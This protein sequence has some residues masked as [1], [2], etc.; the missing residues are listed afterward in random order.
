MS[1][2][3]QP[4]NTFTLC[5]EDGNEYEINEFL[6]AAE[7]KNNNMVTKPTVL[8]SRYYKTA[9]GKDVNYENEEY[10][11]EESSIKLYSCKSS[12]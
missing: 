10:I 12:D 8:P 6:F 3:K 9:D 11:L 1:D 4:I 5:D 7:L 2:N